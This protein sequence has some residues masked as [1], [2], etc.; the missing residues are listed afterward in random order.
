MHITGQKLANPYLA[1][2]YELR[3]NPF[4]YDLFKKEEFKDLVLAIEERMK[5]E[6]E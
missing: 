4:S 5:L 1:S 6:K 3:P 2:G